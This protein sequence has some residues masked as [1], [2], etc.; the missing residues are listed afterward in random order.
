VGRVTQIWA[1]RG[2]SIDCPENTLAAFERA[3]AQ[4]AEGVEFDVQLSADDVPVVIHD[5]Q[6]SRT[7][8]GEGWVRDLPLRALQHLACRRTGTTSTTGIPTLEEVLAVLDG[9]D[10]RINI[11][12]KNS[13]VDY[14]GLEQQ[15]LTAVTRFGIADRT[16]LSSFNHHSVQVLR[17]LGATS[18]LA[19]IL[20]EPGTPWLLPWPGVSAVHPPASALDDPDYVARCR[21][22]GLLVRPW[23]VND[24]D[25]LRR[26]FA[27]GADAVFTDLPALALLVRAQPT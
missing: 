22:A 10:L 25:E 4:G 14:P 26:V 17:S 9:A 1:H 12:L 3:L 13:E 16:V 5:E 21:D 8:A 27:S 7:H 6:V 23:F 15:V 2:A 24:A 20:D 18:E 11:E 19:A